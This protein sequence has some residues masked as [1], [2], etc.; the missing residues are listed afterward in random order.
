MESSLSNVMGFMRQ[1]CKERI[2]DM[3]T[4]VHPAALSDLPKSMAAL[5]SVWPCDL[6]MVSANASLRG[7]CCQDWRPSPANHSAVAG[8][9][10]TQ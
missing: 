4:N 8:G 1:S 3:A 6:W 5:D 9:M 10:G 2:R 7:S